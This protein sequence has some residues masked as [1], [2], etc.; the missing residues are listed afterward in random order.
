MTEA[1]ADTRLVALDA[2]LDELERETGVATPAETDEARTWALSVVDI[3][4]R[5]ARADKPRPR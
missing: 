1:D 3:A 5:S 4:Q 2:F